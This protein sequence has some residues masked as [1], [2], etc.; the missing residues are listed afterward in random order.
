MIG[1][2]NVIAEELEKK[3]YNVIHDTT[4][5]DYP[6]YSGSYNRS[7]DTVKS[8]LK[9]HPSIEVILDVHR[10]GYE[11]IDTRKDRTK[12]IANSKVKINGQNVARFQFVIGAT[13]KNRKKVE[14]FAHFVKAVSDSKYPGFSKEILVKQYGSYNQYLSDHSALIELGANSNTIEEARRA[15]YYFADIID[16]AL[17]LLSE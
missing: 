6:S 14:C 8:I 11:K 13:S 1:A 15:G 16:E 12:L 17:K 2:A 7:A 9:E 4:Y 3:G 10:D 5:H